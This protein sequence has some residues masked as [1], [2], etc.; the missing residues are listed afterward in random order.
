[1]I[2]DNFLSTDTF[3][4]LRAR[5]I[6]NDYKGV[7]NPVDGLEYPDVSVNIPEVVANEI[8]YRLSDLRGRPVDISTMFLRLT[9]ENTK[10]TPHQAHTDT[11]MGDYTLLLYIN[12]GPGGTSYVTHKETGMYGD[13]RSEQELNAWR[14]D[15]KVPDAW[16]I[17]EMV[18]MKKNRANI[19]PADLMHR[20]EP[21]GGFGKDASDGRIVL[22][23][24]FV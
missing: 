11:V 14:R 10:G 5:A 4:S 13:P 15:T 21:A 19:I 7:C 12:D 22:T 8:H 3:E 16:M 17:T 18:N 9:C 20:A 2:V 6:S 23:A 1:M 24:F